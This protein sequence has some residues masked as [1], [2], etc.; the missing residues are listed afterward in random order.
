MLMPAV[1]L[2]GAVLA[3]GAETREVVIGA[4]YRA[5]GFHR[6]LLGEDYRE[7]W[8]MPITVE[9]LDLG[10][11]KGGLTPVRRVGGQQT[12]GLAFKGADGRSY[13][14][15]SVDKDPT[16]ILPP[17]L[18]DTF[19]ASVVQDQIAASHP[20]SAVIAVPILE[21]AGVIHQTPRLVVLPDDPR[22]GE[23]REAFAGQVG[24]FE[25]YPTPGFAGATEILGHEEFWKRL[26]AGQ[27]RPDTRAFLRARLVD[28]LIG[29]WDRHRRQWRWASVPGREG[30]QPIPEDRDQAFARYGGFVLDLVRAQ[31]P[32]LV[33]YG[34]GYSPL[35]GSTWNGRDVDRDLLTGLER[36]VYE[37]IAADLQRRITD[38]VIDAAVAQM[39]EAYQVV[40]A[41]R[42]R[43][44]LRARRDELD[45]EAVRFYEHLAGE[46]DV[47]ATT[48]ADRIR[49]ERKGRT[50]KV[51]I[52]TASGATWFTRT[53][54]DDT[55]DVRIFLVGGG[56]EVTVTGE[57]GPDLRILTAEGRDVITSEHRGRTHVYH[58]TDADRVTGADVHDAPYT[59][60]PPI[61]NA[62]WIPA[63]DWGSHTLVPIPWVGAGGD[64]GVFL[65]AGLVH[66]DFGFHRHPWASRQ[67]LKG[68]F[69]TLAR[70]F[71]VEYEAEVR[72]EDK[73]T[74]LGVRARA[75]GVDVLNFHGF[76]NETSDEGPDRFYRVR[77]EQYVLQPTLAWD[78]G[79]GVL[80]TG[81]IGQ[82]VDTEEDNRRL[83]GQLDPYGTGRFMQA[84]LAADLVIDRRDVPTHARKG[85]VVTLA[86]QVW[87]A[88]FDVDETYG[89]VGAEAAT[90]LTG[91]GRRSPTLAFRAGGA[92]TF[93]RYPFFGAAFLGGGR[94]LRGF[95]AQRFAGDASLF[96]NAE[97]RVPV[98]FVN[99]ALPFEVGLFA[100]TDTG[101][102][103]LEAESS[104]TWHTAIGGGFWISGLRRAAT[105]SFAVA[106]S[107]ERTPIY[108][109][110]GLGF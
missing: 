98:F 71:R 11:E 109:K 13:T 69:A 72:R 36:P 66:T 9:V 99:Y 41:K 85:F 20:A 88:A 16:E 18:K 62:P 8:A 107:D 32:Q 45:E 25:E 84:G 77:Q 54:D 79:F 67:T 95:D 58:P 90:Y 43:R 1:L 104:S 34:R 102:V 106:H 27:A 70:T 35:E 82:W 87:P 51:E 86:G 73:A 46:V 74:R 108:I 103:W 94:N 53:F 63:R 7:L 22:L 44:D 76:G 29:D 49:A 3:E 28:L 75:S 92:Q 48:G 97:I 81:P 65:G 52:T 39:P 93:G 100:F 78:V 91:H 56:D 40:D 57:G 83:I 61:A 38:E 17:D 68:G 64:I 10:A 59:P 60:P 50:L 89:Q 26:R 6:F 30:F 47:F 2:A 23:F 24:T 12:R 37:E 19:A 80:T 14:F 110:A 4:R 15:R 5:G 42:L 21:A 55:N 105:F 101:R 96:G 31:F 33:E